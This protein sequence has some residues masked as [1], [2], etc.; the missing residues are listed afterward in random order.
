MKRLFGVLGFALLLAAGCKSVETTSAI[1]HND[2]GRYDLAIEKANEA[3]AKNPDDP[4]A[5]FQ[6][7]IAYS[8]LDSVG[9][10][11]EHFTQAKTIDPKRDKMVDDN[12]QSNYA[13]HYNQALN[14]QKE[15][16]LAPAAEEFKRATEADPTQSKGFYML[17]RMYQTM[18][19]DDTKYHKN[20]VAAYDRV[21][22]L[23][24][25]ADKHYIDAL[26]GAGQTLARAGKPEEAVSRF[27]RLVEEDP[28]NYRIIEDIGYSRLDQKDWKGAT[29]FLELSDLARSKIGAENFDLNYNIGVAYY[30]LGR[31]DEDPD[32][33]AKSVVWY[34]KALELQPDEPTTM[35]NIVVAYVVGEEWMQAITWGEKYVSVKADDPN[36]WRL[37]SRSYTEMGN[38]G[39]ARQ[40]AARYEELRRGQ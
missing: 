27:N 30:Q 24:T 19:E 6:L 9:M 34:Q 32:N 25:P 22:E 20:A 1:L 11:F 38:E 40:C 23:A 29:V 31:Q 21:L 3:L 35:Y 7:G 15:Q 33:I 4:E 13:R 2:A 39:K 36:G 8:K 10:A 5:H 26:S 16:D 17:G 37:L 12:I 28:T 18:G 14:L